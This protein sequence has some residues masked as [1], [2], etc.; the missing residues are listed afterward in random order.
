[1]FFALFTGT[2]CVFT[3]SITKTGSIETVETSAVFLDNTD[4]L[5]KIQVL[6]PTITTVDKTTDLNRVTKA[7]ISIRITDKFMEA[8]K[9]KEMFTLSFTRPETGETITSAPAS[10]AI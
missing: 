4:F 3:K 2:Y 8:V 5:T 9:K 1:M 10:I 6:D 7:N